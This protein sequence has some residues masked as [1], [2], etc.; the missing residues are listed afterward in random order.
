[1]NEHCI[2][3]KHEGDIH[4]FEFL[5][6]SRQAIDEWLATLQMIIDE[7][8]QL[9]CTLLDFSPSGLPPVM[10]F[11]ENLRHHHLLHRY[12]SEARTAVIY[13]QGAGIRAA[14]QALLT[15]PPHQGTNE[16]RIFPEDEWEQ[17]LQWLQEERV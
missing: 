16:T 11:S 5:I 4:C 8:G 2:Y 13:P 3:Y 1:M 7:E 9:G 15:S 10:Y 6:T 12:L 14:L 17:A